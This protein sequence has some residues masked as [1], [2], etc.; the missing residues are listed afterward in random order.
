MNL[1]ED[2]GFLYNGRFSLFKPEKE[3]NQSLNTL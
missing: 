2:L 1:L 3:N